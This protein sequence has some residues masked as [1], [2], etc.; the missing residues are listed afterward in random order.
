MFRFPVNSIRNSIFIRLVLTYLS[1]IL[2]ILALGVYLYHWSAKNA[3]EEISRATTTQLSYYMEDLNREIE[4]LEIQQYDLVQDNELNQLAVAWE[5]MN[6][7]E[8]T[9]GMN[10]LIQ[11]LTSIKNSSPYI[12]DVYVHL[13][14]IRKTVSAA[15]DVYEFQQGSFDDLLASLG[16]EK[17][18]LI[19]WQQTFHLRAS[20]ASGEAGGKP[21]FIVQIVLDAERLKESMKQLNS[22]E[23]SGSFVMDDRSSFAIASD[24]GSSEM[25]RQSAAL[26]RSSSASAFRLELDGKEY[27]FN[28]VSS[29]KLGLTGFIYMPAETVAKPL[30]KFEVW[31]WLFAAATLMTIL[32]YAYSTYRFV[33]KPLLLL[34]QSFRRM[35]GGAL[36]S[37]IE[38]EQKD[39]FG[40]LYHR[41]NHMLKKLQM[42]IDQDFKQKLMMQKAE[43]KQLQSQINPHFLYNSFFILNSLARTGDTDRIEQ[44]TNMLGEYFRFITRSGADLVPLAEET[45][46]SRMYTEIQ[47]LRF[48]RRI[49]VEF[50]ELPETMRTISVPRLIIQPIIE[51]AYEHSLEK[52][53][54]EGLLRV[55][56]EREEDEARIVVENNGEPIG[57]SLLEELRRRLDS[58]SDSYEMTGMIN[59][60]RR[61]LLTYG[62]GSG[63]SLSRS[64]LGGLKVAIR[65]RLKETV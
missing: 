52:V 43:L 22:Y 3:R 11:R 37:P 36:D 63:L 62:E 65:I 50:G 20:K 30:S 44:F 2:P 9:A 29:A 56:F 64:E 38:H 59:I 28:K 32:I 58:S 60:H 19:T 7:V 61:I 49:A 42:L 26:A 8:R 23:E 45:R 5:K 31:A 10:Y 15:H 47:E 17:T 40:Y 12:K 39:E 48:S 6:G 57:E 54:E 4:W 27:Q 34:V 33:H 41:F 18:R 55:S 21:L 46:H 13:H 16:K 25:M 35:E 24:P 53:T 14:S 1:V 51:N